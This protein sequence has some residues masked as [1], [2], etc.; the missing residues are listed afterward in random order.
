MTRYWDW[1]TSILQ[2]NLGTSV[3]FHEP[4]TDVLGP[5]VETTLFLVG[6][7][8]VLIVVVG[9]ALGIVG[10]RTPGWL[11]S[12]ITAVTSI[13]LATPAFVAA[14]GLTLLFA[15]KLTWFPVF[16]S[17]GGFLGRL[18]HLTLP[19]I[20]LAIGGVAL[21]ARITRAAVRTELAAEHVET[22]RSRGLSELRVLRRHA[23]RNA[24]I[25]VT[26]ASGL[27]VG[28]LIAG[29]AVVETAF[30]ISGGGS[31]LVQSVEVKDFPV[32]QAVCLIMVIAFATINSGVDLLYSV[33]DPRIRRA[34]AHDAAAREDGGAGA[35]S[36]LVTVP[37][38]V[39]TRV[40]QRRRW[41]ALLGRGVGAHTAWLLAGVVIVGIVVCCALAPWIAPYSPDAVDLANVSAGSSTAHL[42]GTDGVGRDLLSRLLFGG[43]STLL[44]PLLV[45]LGAGL[46]GTSLAMLSAWMGR[47]VDYVIARAFDIMFAFPS[48]LLA[49]LA[50]A[51]LGAG[52]KTMT[53]ALVIAY[54]PYVGRIIRSEAVRQRNLPY[55]AA[56]TLAGEIE[57]RN[58]AGA[59]CSRTLR[60]SSTRS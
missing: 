53:I 57:C 11:D 34:E 40:L 27:T 51:V 47:W 32:V 19:A 31:L 37:A 9:V 1:L 48:I 26:T 42:L 7:A 28:S 56:A 15:V 2:G 35:L 21:L 54:T 10:A 58:L 55:I 44:V 33:I 14:V 8:G 45:T 49:I 13:G 5:R 24:L 6:Y 25:P 38:S 3:E 17:G 52:L 4:V 43:R 36:T 30:G 16:G 59:T 39:P 20:A 41:A 46:A 22:A 60:H 18:S 29:T 23:V 50:T 12:A